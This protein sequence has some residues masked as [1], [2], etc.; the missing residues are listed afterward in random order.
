M[1]NE[2]LHVL[3]AAW[4]VCKVV[5]VNQTCGV[6]ISGAVPFIF[7]IITFTVLSKSFNVLQALTGGK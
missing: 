6:D 7:N 4:Q 1:N 3:V 2:K 5:T